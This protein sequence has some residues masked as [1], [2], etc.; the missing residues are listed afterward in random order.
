MTYLTYIVDSIRNNGILSTI[1]KMKKSLL[2]RPSAEDVKSQAGYCPCCRSNTTFISNHEWLRDHYL[3]VKCSS[4]PRQRH[5][6]HVLDVEFPGWESLNV[7]ESSPSNRLISMNSKK[8]SFSHFLDGVEHIFDPELAAR[9]I[10]RVLRPG[11]AHIFTAPKHDNV[12]VSYPRARLDR[13]EIVHIFDEHYHG[14]PVGD[15]KSL[16][17]WD[18]GSD[19]EALFSKWTGY[20][21]ETH[22]DENDNLGINGKY[23]DVFV[24]R[25]V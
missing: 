21:V 8:Y 1:K 14:N 4:I 11:G 12:K 16:V 6:E 25:K 24:V 19:F 9:E 2:S 17:T 22:S 5:I 7:H 23:L 20:E 13:G 18:Y 15:G 3:C 10:M